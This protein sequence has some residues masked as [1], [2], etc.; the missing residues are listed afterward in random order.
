MRNDLKTTVTL[1]KSVKRCGCVWIGN[2][3]DVACAD[4][5]VAAK[6]LNRAQALIV[7]GDIER[8]IL[9]R[10]ITLLEA[11]VAKG[12]TPGL[13][14]RDFDQKL[15]WACGVVLNGIGEGKFHSAVASV[16]VLVNNEAY[17]RGRRDGARDRK[18]KS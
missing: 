16:M 7:Q 14:E 1:H 8:E 12:P 6:N 3:Q 15:S 13:D 2:V 9:K 18:R 4:H 11:L 10:R 5:N 17:Q